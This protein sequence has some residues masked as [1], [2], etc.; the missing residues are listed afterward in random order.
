VF[1]CCNLCCNAWV[2]FRTQTAHVV[3][4]LYL[5]IVFYYCYISTGRSRVRESCHCKLKLSRALQQHVHLVFGTMSTRNGTCC[6]TKWLNEN[7]K[8]VPNPCKSNNKLNSKLSIALQHHVFEMMFTRNETRCNKN[9]PNEH[10][11]RVTLVNHK[12]NQNKLLSRALQH[13][14][15]FV[16]EIVFMRSVGTQNG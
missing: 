4:T 10:L 12:N 11:A 6:N 13:H 3:A 8:R 1:L 5:A 16:F 15:H 14:V 2:L 7:V 9:G